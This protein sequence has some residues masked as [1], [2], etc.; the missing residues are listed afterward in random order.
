VHEAACDS[1]HQ[2][3]ALGAAPGTKINSSDPA[4]TAVYTAYSSEPFQPWPV[5]FH[6][7]IKLAGMRPC[8]HL[9]LDRRIDRTPVCFAVS[10]R[11]EIHEPLEHAYDFDVRYRRPERLNLST[12]R[13][14]ASSLGGT[15][16]DHRTA[17]VGRGDLDHQIVQAFLVLDQELVFGHLGAAA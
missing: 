3:S 5:L 1:Q 9:D 13:F 14:R 2:Q 7:P 11:I 15:L 4:L 17:I 6:P 12:A 16:E 8:G 10:A